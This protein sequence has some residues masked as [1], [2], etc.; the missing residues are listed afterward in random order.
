[1]TTTQ[2][3]IT[4]VM[5]FLGGSSVTAGVGYLF[6]RPKTRAEAAAKR[7][8][9]DNLDVRSQGEIITRW[10]EYAADLEKR[11]KIVEGRVDNADRREHLVAIFVYQASTWMQRATEAMDPQQRTR[12]GA[13]PE[14]HPSL[15]EGL[16]APQWTPPA[17][18]PNVPRPGG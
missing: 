6:L 1:M 8:E 14:P 12:V 13:A 18:T 16:G 4:T 11:L 17:P 7:A 2:V 9:G 15:F 5:V 10:R 3:L